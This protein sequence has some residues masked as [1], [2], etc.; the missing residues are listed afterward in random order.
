M[1]EG[2]GPDRRSQLVANLALVR[3]RIAAV[4][5]RVGRDPRELTLVAVTKTFPA[6]DLA[7]LAALDIRD[8]GENREQEARSKFEASGGLDLRWHFVG[9][10]QT[11]KAPRVCRYFDVVHSVDRL[12]LVRALD[13]AAGQ[14]R[15]H[16]SVFVQVSL[17]QRPGRGGA[18]PAAVGELA[19][20]VGA[21]G[22]LSLS[23]VMAVAPPDE[24]PGLAF[25]RLARI[26]AQLQSVHPGAS[27]ISA[28]MSADFELAIA[29]GATHI[30]LGTALLG[31][32]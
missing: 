30:R 7:H 24:P 12:E 4:C 17:Q 2:G 13:A 21:A 3:E 8:V 9:Q 26:A 1:I 31:R 32:R 20:A 16:L 29:H 28:G 5:R 15:R 19:D 11:N 22:N 10:L 14:A 6:S 18:D 25:D 23:G 27:A